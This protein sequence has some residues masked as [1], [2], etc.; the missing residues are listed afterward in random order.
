[1]VTPLQG[2]IELSV[3]GGLRYDSRTNFS[4]SFSLY[5]DCFSSEEVKNTPEGL[6][7]HLKRMDNLDWIKYGKREGFIFSSSGRKM[8][9]YSVSKLRYLWM[10]NKNQKIVNQS[11]DAVAKRN[12]RVKTLVDGI[13][14]KF[15]G[16]KLS[17]IPELLMSMDNLK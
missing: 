14:Q 15:F 7:A 13:S 5:S 8:D 6:S 4:K 10:E 1:M 11:Y 3:T 2:R 12:G 16:E 17:R 9:I